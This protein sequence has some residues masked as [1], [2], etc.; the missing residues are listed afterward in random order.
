MNNCINYMLTAKM[1]IFCSMRKVL[2]F[3]IDISVSRAGNIF[4]SSPLT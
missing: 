2:S 1:N 4:L 3:Y